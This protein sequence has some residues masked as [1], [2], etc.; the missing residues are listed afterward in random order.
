MEDC[1]KPVLESV[2]ADT[3][4]KNNIRK[5]ISNFFKVR[6]CHTLIR[7]VDDEET[8]ANIEQLDWESKAIKAEF[9]DS[10]NEFMDQLKQTC[11]VKQIHGKSFNGS[12]LLGLAMDFCD[13]VNDEDTPK[14]ESSVM[15]L[16]QE[17]TQIIQD[18]AY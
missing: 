18:D 9:R 2:S 8:L 5:I 13:A 6:Q 1:L 3:L 17:E 16:V 10:C 12:M 14:I 11:R 7:P 15:R 4:K